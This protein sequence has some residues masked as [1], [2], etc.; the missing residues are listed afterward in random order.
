MDHKAFFIAACLAGGFSTATFAANPVMDDVE[1]DV[2]ASAEADTSTSA[3][4]NDNV[5]TQSSTGAKIDSMQ[6]TAAENISDAAITTK[7]KSK[8]LADTTTKGMKIDVDTTA[9]V[10]TLNGNVATAAEKAQAEKLA[11]ETE[12]VKSVDNKL[13][14]GAKK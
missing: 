1:G 6:N 11:K 9:G 12:G 5:E 10:V 2:T 4:A 13:T 3:S 8:L 7:V 14:V